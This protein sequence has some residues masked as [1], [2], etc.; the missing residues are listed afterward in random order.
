MS[1]FLGYFEGF[2]ACFDGNFA[3]QKA[4]IGSER[5]FCPFFEKTVLFQLTKDDGSA[6]ITHTACYGRRVFSCHE[7]VLAPDAASP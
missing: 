4:L 1:M 3:F 7:A 6:I 5:S 2:F